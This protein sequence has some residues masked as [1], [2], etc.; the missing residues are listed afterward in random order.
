M[1]ISGGQAI[2][3]Y[4]KTFYVNVLKQKIFDCQGTLKNKYKKIY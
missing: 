2:T 1:K 3:N 4:L